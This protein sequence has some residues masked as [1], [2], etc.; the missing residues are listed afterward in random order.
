MV[1]CVFPI[2]CQVSRFLQRYYSKLLLRSGDDFP[3]VACVL[4]AVINTLHVVCLDPVFYLL[5]SGVVLLVWVP[6]AA[7][8]QV[9]SNNRCGGR[10]DLPHEGS[11]LSITGFRVSRWPVD[12]YE[13]EWVVSLW[14]WWWWP[15]Q[16]YFQCPVLHWCRVCLGARA[17]G[18]LL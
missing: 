13:D 11:L 4:M 2:G 18:L 7:G 3:P 9:P 6:I 5:S 16:I 14:L 1:G 17:I 10:W 8:I 15:P 12:V